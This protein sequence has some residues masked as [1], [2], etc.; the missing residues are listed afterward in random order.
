[1]WG[2]TNAK[3]KVSHLGLHIMIN[4]AACVVSLCQTHESLFECRDS[5]YGLM[6]G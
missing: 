4:A 2:V 3:D 5:H 1:M 6:A